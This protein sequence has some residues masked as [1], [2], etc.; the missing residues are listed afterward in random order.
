MLMGEL[1][2]GKTQF[3]KGLAQGLGVSECLTSPTFTYEAIYPA[4]D[5]FVLYH[6]DLYRTE[7]IDPDIAAF[8]TEAINDPKG[9]V[10]IE[11]AERAKEI[12][13]KHYKILNFK[14]ISENEREI[15]LDE[16]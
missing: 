7:I 5:N 13:P 12:W 1:G 16:K 4:R 9:V 15:I 8:V 14:W 11:W 10:A 2:C 3:V 6:F